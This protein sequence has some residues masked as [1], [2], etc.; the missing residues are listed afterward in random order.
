[1]RGIT[2]VVAIILLLLMTV[3]IAGFAFLFFTRTAQTAAESG[4]QQLQQQLAQ[5]ASQFSIEG[6]SPS[7]QI[8]VRNRGSAPLG[9]FSVFVDD[10]IVQWSASPVAPGSVGTINVM[11]AVGPGTHTV[12]VCTVSLCDYAL[13][14]VRDTLT[15]GLVL[16]LPM[17]EGSGTSTADASGTGNNGAISGAAWTSGKSGSALQFDGTDDMVQTGTD[18]MTSTAF[19]LSFWIMPFSTH[20][21]GIY[22]MGSGL[23]D[24]G[25]RMR[26]SSS[27]QICSGIAWIAD[28][29]YQANYSTDT[30]HHFAVTKQTNGTWTLYFNGVSVKSAFDTNPSVITG[31][32]IGRFTGGVSWFHFNGKIDEAR[33]YNRSL[34]ESE[35]SQ[36]YARG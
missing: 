2:P 33:V 25:V 35:I 16:Y 27:G 9:N 23:G 17:N 4:E 28:Y 1:M 24:R 10:A 14:Y 22:S 31:S 30:W 8:Y 6:T 34:S 15:D 32:A 5:G 19:T 3:S 13:N 21:G 7:G 11:T 12:K 18:Q 26:V 36:L 29:C 20:D